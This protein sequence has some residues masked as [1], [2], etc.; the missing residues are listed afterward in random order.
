[1][2]DGAPEARQVEF[3]ILGPLEVRLGGRAAVP[4]PGS[5]A[6]LGPL[7]LTPGETVEE[8]RLADLLWGPGGASRGALHTSV[9]RLRSWLRS[10]LG[11]GEAIERTAAGY[12]IDLPTETVD[13]ARFHAATGLA[14]HDSDPNTRV[15]H[16]RSALDEWRGPVLA[17]APEWVRTDPV[18]TGLERSR[19][20]HARELADAALRAGRP[21]VALGHLRQV[22]TALPYDEPLQ[23]TL[24]TLLGA[25]GR[26]AE[27]LRL[28]E[29]ARQRLAD[30]L[31][32]DPSDELREAH[33][34][35]L[36]S[37]RDRPTYP[38]GD[39]SAEEPEDDAER[40]A[41]V[42]VPAQLPPDTAAFLGRGAELERL[43][44]TVKPAA[45]GPAVLVTIN[46]PGGVGKSALAVH[47]AHQ[48]AE[49]FPDGTLYANLQGASPGLEPL[50]PSEVLARWLR[51]LDASETQATGN[52]HE[53][54][55]Q[56][57]SLLSGQRV[58]L[59]L[60]GALDESQVQPL[61]PTSPG[62]AAVL[63][64]RSPLTALDNA[65][66]VELDVLEPAQAV[67]LLGRIAGPR[68][69]A[70]EP[71][72]ATETARLC[73]YLPLALRVCG[74]RLAARPHWRVGEL[75]SRLHGE[76]G[77]LDQLATATWRFA[78]ASH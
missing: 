17:D 26:R 70:D 69:V 53:A 21:E 12:R 19:A 30:E 42:P 35:L 10:R 73:G 52:L 72:A 56:F 7:L 9:S 54:T 60:D 40:A 41:A 43:Y 48:L 49:R 68:R 38:A 6:L 34:T 63:T 33:L 13:V 75:A 11:L 61:L 57:R 15:E 50:E 65:R 51:A 62:C 47:A 59:V 78:R 20:D 28:F 5:R 71:D 31:G 32:V 37:D 74:A 44:E 66:R 55:A 77:R 64:S 16:L 29:E 67:Q 2:A 1:M 76:W 23:A 24:I 36:R 22:A 45:G 8:E 25:C 4:S 18:V 46:G 14:T 58:L 27:G 3:A 39:E